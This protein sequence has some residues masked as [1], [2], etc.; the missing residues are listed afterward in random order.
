MK[1]MS[2]NIIILSLCQIISG[3]RVRR[4]SIGQ[5]RLLN[6]V[7]RFRN[8]IQRRALI[9]QRDNFDEQIGDWINANRPCEEAQRYHVVMRRHNARQNRRY[10]KFVNNWKEH[11]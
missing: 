6:N 3:F 9:G 1:I 10:R 7:E 2:I 8:G 4:D 11:F 5:N